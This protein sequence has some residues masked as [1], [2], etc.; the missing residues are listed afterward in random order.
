[1]QDLV[2]VHGLVVVE[3]GTL[4]HVSSDC[5]QVG[6]VVDLVE[7]LQVLFVDLAKIE[8]VL[9]LPVEMSPNGLLEDLKGLKI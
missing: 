8:L 3:L 1:M 7:G 9:T 5:S 6:V 2:A 4:L